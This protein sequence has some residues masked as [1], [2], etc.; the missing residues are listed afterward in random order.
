[1]I[2]VHV[3]YATPSAFESD[4]DR[5]VVGMAANARR[6]V[7]FHGRIVRQVPLLRFAL[8]A[9]GAAI[10][11]DDSW[12]PSGERILDPVVTVHPD[13][14]F[15]EAFSGD[16]STYVQV[17]VDPSLFEVEGEVR[18]GTTNVDFTAWLWAALSELRSS[19][20]T[21]LRIDAGGF[22]V[23]TRGAG[24]RYEEKVELPDDWVRGFLQ[25]QAAMAMPG[26]LLTVRAVDLLAAIRYLRVT[27][28]K[29]SPRALRYEFE[30]GKEARIVLEP[31][32]AVIPLEGTEHG[33]A[34]RRVVRTWGRRRLRLIEPLL[35]FADRVDIFLKGRALPS[36]YAVKMPGI[37]FVLGL[38]GWSSLRWTETAGLEVPAL[39][40]AEADAALLPRAHDFLAGRRTAGVEALAEDLGTPRETAARLLERL[41]RQGRAI[42]DVERREYRHRELF[43]SPPDEARLF[44]PDPRRERAAAILEKGEVSVESCQPRE[45]RK[46]KVLRT[47][48]GKETREVIH[49]D[50]QVHGSA[51]DERAV[52][53]VVDDRGRI[54]FG[55]CG[56]PFF[57]ENILNRGP[58][59]HMAALFAASHSMRED[60]PTSG[61]A[62][63][64]GCG[65]P[66]P[67]RPPRER[68]G[69]GEGEAGEEKD[70]ADPGAA[71]PAESLDR[72]EEMDELD[73]GEKP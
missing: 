11:S 24:G 2:P 48:H 25:L 27:K 18:P 60:L 54:I 53:I 51:G 10:W 35:P 23:R 73:G 61:E 39:P 16:A 31:W 36:F 34:K 52:E 47:P 9:L 1:M 38:T 7:R 59:E 72:G 49:R 26:T 42:Y 13:R 3:E 58:C 17:I 15:F 43:E 71:G 37:T 12:S 28:A 8:R 29:L 19:R 50:W 64:D 20:E 4:R 14:I 45:T 44:P 57:R 67:A 21:W 63:A 65:G 56:C 41:C 69:E 70:A 62:P 40:G 33:Y 30:P 22:E 46:L 68:E 55:T 32:E 6:P 5:A 66:R